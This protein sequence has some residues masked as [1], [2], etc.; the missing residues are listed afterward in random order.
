MPG[1]WEHIWRTGLYRPAED[2]PHPELG[3]NML[4]AAQAQVRA[5]AR[6]LQPVAQTRALLQ[7]HGRRTV[8]EQPRYVHRSAG[9]TKRRA[10]RRTRAHLQAWSRGVHRWWPPHFRTAV[11]TLLLVAHRGAQAAAAQPSGSAATY[12][13]RQQRARRVAAAPSQLL[14]GILARAAFP[15][16]AWDWRSFGPAG[17][18]YLR[19]RD[20]DL[21]DSD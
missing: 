12:M 9:P 11:R 21:E 5:A 14:D 17:D 3:P 8:L 7:H 2:M 4:R 19:E 13:T 15:L 20:P 1:D 16:S 18:Y 10:F 6:P